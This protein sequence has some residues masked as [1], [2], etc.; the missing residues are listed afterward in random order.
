MLLLLFICFCMSRLSAFCEGE[1]NNNRKILKCS[2]FFFLHFFASL[3]YMQI[4]IWERSKETKKNMK[5]SVKKKDESM[6]QVMGNLYEICAWD[7]RWHTGL[8]FFFKSLNWVNVWIINYLFL[9]E[10]FE[11]R[12]NSRPSWL[13]FDVTDVEFWVFLSKNEHLERVAKTRFASVFEFTG[14]PLQEKNLV[15]FFLL[16]LLSQI[17][18]YFFNLYPILNRTP[19]FFL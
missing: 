12:K 3:H 17:T 19:C 9:Y 5:W 11:S 13:K 2:A 6:W 7:K 14:A 10:I 8:A 15:K 16:A 4:E 1:E 18:Q